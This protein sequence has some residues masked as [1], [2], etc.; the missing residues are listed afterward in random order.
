MNFTGGDP[1]RI[2]PSL[3]FVT[4]LSAATPIAAE[5]VQDSVIAQLRAFG[6][7]E[8]SERRTLLGRVLITGVKDGFQREIVVNPRTGEILRDYNRSEPFAQ[9]SVPPDDGNRDARVPPPVRGGSGNIPPPPGLSP[10]GRPAPPPW[11][12]S[13]G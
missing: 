2:A 8:I 9:R 10:D 5:S 13:P 4:V 3:L 1:M 11:R 12:R 6:Y 7:G